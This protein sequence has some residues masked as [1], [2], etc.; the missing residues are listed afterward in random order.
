MLLAATIDVCSR[1]VAVHVYTR[2][3]R[4]SRGLRARASTASYVIA[5]YNAITRR[6]REDDRL[7]Q[8]RFALCAIT[9]DRDLRP[10]EGFLRISTG[11]SLPGRVLF[12]EASRRVSTRLSLA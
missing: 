12:G 9:D 6:I 3:S 1:Y 5:Q 8:Y 7:V 11:A 10:D 4:L 2:N